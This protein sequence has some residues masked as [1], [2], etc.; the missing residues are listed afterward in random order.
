MSVFV[1]PDQ[2]LAPAE[3]A[4][5][6]DVDVRFIQIAISAGCPVDVSGRL[7]ARALWHWFKFHYPKFRQAAGMRVFRPKRTGTAEFPGSLG[8]EGVLAT[9]VEF[10]GVLPC[11]AALESANRVLNAHSRGKRGVTK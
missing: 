2:P 11:G 1:D 6:L 8:T 10:F 5:H 9:I 4:A 3:L 7:T